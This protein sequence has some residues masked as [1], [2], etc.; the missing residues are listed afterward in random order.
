MFSRRSK[1]LN[2]VIILLMIAFMFYVFPIDV[3][4]GR[5]INTSSSVISGRENVW[6]GYIENLIEDPLY[7]VRGAILKVAQL[8]YF[9]VILFNKV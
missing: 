4:F 6:K 8:T 3:L 7:I 2:T 5:F 9:R 1:I